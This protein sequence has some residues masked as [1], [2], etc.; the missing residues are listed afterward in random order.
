MIS[1]RMLEK[2][3]KEALEFNES[4]RCFRDPS[5]PAKEYM[6]CCEK[7]LKLTQELIDQYLLNKE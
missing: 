6:K 4:V 2:W 1:K 3:R 5:V 7:I